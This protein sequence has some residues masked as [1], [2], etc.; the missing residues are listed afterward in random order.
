[1]SDYSKPSFPR[2]SY[3]NKPFGNKG[4]FQSGPREMFKANCAKCGNECEVPFRPNGTKPVYCNN[5]FV[6]DTPAGGDRGP[7]RDFAPRPSFQS[8]PQ[9]PR[10]DQAFKDLKAELR[11]VNQ[12]L[13]RMISLMNVAAQAPKAAHEPKAPKAPKKKAK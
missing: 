6:R 13:E 12:N 9:A 8:A 10:D 5:C 4:G 1:M 3:G 7:R 2:K 11:L